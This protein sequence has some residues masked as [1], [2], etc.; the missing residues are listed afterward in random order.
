MPRKPNSCQTHGLIIKGFP[1]ATHCLRVDVVL[2]LEE[3]L[4]GLSINHFLCEGLAHDPQAFHILNAYLQ[5]LHEKSSLVSNTE[6][7]EW[8][9][10]LQ[11]LSRCGEESEFGHVKSV[12]V[13]YEWS[14][15]MRLT[16]TSS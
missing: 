11:S 10:E 5:G 9:I 4:T 6:E 2:L 16:R 3:N 7:Y 1:A 13:S 15:P 12:C 8:Q 14:T